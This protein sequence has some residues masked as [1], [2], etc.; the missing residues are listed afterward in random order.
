MFTGPMRMHWFFY[1]DLYGILGMMKL[2]DRLQSVLRLYE[3]CSVAADIGTDHGYL[4]IFLLQ[5]GL[6]KKVYACDVHEGPL[7]AAKK[8]AGIY[9]N[10]AQRCALDFVLGDGMQGIR[11]K[12]VDACFLC[13]MGGALILRIVDDAISFARGADQLIVQPQSQIERCRD[14]LAKRGFVS[15]DEELCFDEKKRIFYQSMK[16]RYDAQRVGETYA[17]VDGISKC[18][19]EK[20]HILLRPFI[21]YQIEGM[22]SVIKALGNSSAIDREEK[23]EALVQKKE[24]LERV[25]KQV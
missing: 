22:E 2:N 4:P 5:K 21:L 14:E 19:L 24:A 7:E 23:R 6:A 25:V 18:L 1:F 12:K 11:E 10:D 16:V 17:R 3:P 15:V 13:G 8:N 20:G 9:L